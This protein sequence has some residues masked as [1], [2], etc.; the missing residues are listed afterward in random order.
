[1]SNWHTLESEIAS[2][3]DNTQ[4]LRRDMIVCSVCS[5]VQIWEEKM[6]PL[7]IVISLADW[8][9]VSAAGSCEH[10]IRN[11]QSSVSQATQ[12]LTRMLRVLH[13]G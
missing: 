10:Q 8:Q 11:N 2:N 5:K 3:Y 1:M 9:D 4:R 7:G 6:H 12:L 13:V